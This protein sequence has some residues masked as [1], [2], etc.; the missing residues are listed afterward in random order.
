V[1]GLLEFDEFRIAGPNLPDVQYRR[2]ITETMSH[3]GSAVPPSG[4]I[5]TRVTKL[6]ESIAQKAHGKSVNIIAYASI[7]LG[8]SSSTYQL[9]A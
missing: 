2:G 7:I 3:K 1:H 8:L 9:Q 5:E 4:S 6:G